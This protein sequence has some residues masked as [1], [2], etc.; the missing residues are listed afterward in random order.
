MVELVPGINVER[1]EL[2]VYED[3]SSKTNTN[4]TVIYRDVADDEAGK[5]RILADA[6]KKYKG[7]KYK[8]TDYGH[9][10]PKSKIG[11]L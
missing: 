4:D 9:K 5:E 6:T 3:I 1:F 2:D 7:F 8:L 11:I 10:K